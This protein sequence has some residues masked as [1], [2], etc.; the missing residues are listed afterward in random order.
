VCRE[1]DD[2]QVRAV[3]L[4]PLQNLDAVEPGELQVE[5]DDVRP[6]GASPF[7]GRRTVVGGGHL[8]TISRED[9]FHE[10]ASGLVVIDDQEP[11]RAG[12]WRGHYGNG[13]RPLA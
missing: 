5:D 7:E 8:E 3:V 9:G 11:R 6:V 10:A 13:T 2:R 4:E 12:G 1:H